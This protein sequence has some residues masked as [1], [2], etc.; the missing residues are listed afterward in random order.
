MLIIDASPPQPWTLASLPAGSLSFW[1]DAADLTT[2]TI[3]SGVSQ[4]RD[5]SGNSRHF[6]QLTLANRPTYGAFSLANISLVGTAGSNSPR[7]MDTTAIWSPPANFDF[8]WVATSDEAPQGNI[9]AI[10]D[11]DHASLA[12]GNANWVIQSDNVNFGNSPNTTTHYF[13]QNIT[14]T[15]FQFIGNGSNGITTGNS[16]IGLVRRQS[17]ASLVRNSTTI[18][19]ATLSSQFRSD[20]AFR[21]GGCLAYPDRG[22]R[23]GHAEIVYTQ[24][25]LSIP[26]IQLTTGYL[27]W[28]WNLQSLLPTNHPFRNRAPLVSDV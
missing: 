18:A 17:S 16:V 26:E 1:L 22:W 13:A 4:W 24:R 21:V 15:N 3:V 11:H 7:F 10:Y 6:N 27:A 23:G 5:K 12:Q 8:F 9:N 28:K 14:S 25:S 19:T 2:L 20:R